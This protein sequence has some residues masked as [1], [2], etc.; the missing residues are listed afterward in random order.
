MKHLALALAL[1]LP[2][3]GQ[4]KDPL[5]QPKKGDEPAEKK[6]VVYVTEWPALDKS[7]TATVKTDI[8]RL[9]KS[10]TPEM[11]EQAD[12]ALSAVGAGI[13][14][15]LLPVLGK[16]RNLEA[17]L[18]VESVLDKVTGPEH[19]RVL[20]P[21]LAD[22]SR[23][24]RIWTLHRC[25]GF[26]DAA[27]R[28][29]AEDA[30]AKAV[31]AREKE[32]KSDEAATELYEAALCA[33]SA[34]SHQGFERVAQAALEQ[35]GK[36]GVE[37]RVALEAVRDDEATAL[38][39]VLAQDPDRKKKVCGLNLLAGC[40]T[41]AAIA[42]VKPSLDSTDN[43]IRIAAINA[44]RGIVDGDPPIANLPVFEAI[45]LAKKWKTRA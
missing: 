43:S 6:E 17:C 40:G 5:F 26:P 35:W 19:T 13:V 44:M 31:V 42:V 25:A 2:A 39:S 14:P 21:F 24:V 12:E 10:N 18:R 15:L 23:E 36:K 29:A 11:G 8:E 32:P 34:G 33:T 27:I 38:A 16:E 3:F 41:K 1:A 37:I 45:E 9:R 22:K 30:L 4:G 28:A 20:A 7:V